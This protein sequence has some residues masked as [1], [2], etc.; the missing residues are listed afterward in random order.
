MS[1]DDSITRNKLIGCKKFNVCLM[2]CL[3][4]KFHYKSDNSKHHFS[5]FF[6]V[7]LN[8]IS[9]IKIKLF[10]FKRHIVHMKII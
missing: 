9:Y 4:E 6:A 2:C 3:T 7:F 8:F 10:N 5:D 1:N